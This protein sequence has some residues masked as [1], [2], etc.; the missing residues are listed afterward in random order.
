MLLYNVKKHLDKAGDWSKAVIAERLSEIGLIDDTFL[1][2]Q[3]EKSN[4]TFGN[5][6]HYSN[7][8]L[9]VV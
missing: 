5:D 2:K 7:K 3:E 4:E 1:W 6:F 8:I 9:L